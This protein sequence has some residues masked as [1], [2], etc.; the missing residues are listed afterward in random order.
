MVTENEDEAKKLAEFRKNNSAQNQML[1]KDKT[2]LFENA[3][4]KDELNITIK[5]MFRVQAKHL[6]W[7]LIRLNIMKLK[8]NYFIRY[9]HD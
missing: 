2:T 8:Q 4:D 9:W 6:K 7:Q 3:K 5:L 1:T